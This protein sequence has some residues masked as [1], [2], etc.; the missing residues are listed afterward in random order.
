MSEHTLKRENTIGITYV[1][2][3]IEDEH[4]EL[5]IENTLGVQES[6]IEGIDDRG[7][8]RFVF[9]V[10][11][12]EVYDCICEHFAGREIQIGN[13]NVIQVDDISS[14]GTM[15][16][17]SRVPFEIDN[18]VLTFNQNNNANLGLTTL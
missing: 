2:G 10:S 17:V 1:V 18:D 6:E 14:Y 3:E 15:V 4:Y 9:K 7:T 5:I 13:G 16:E 11:T 12:S 8:T